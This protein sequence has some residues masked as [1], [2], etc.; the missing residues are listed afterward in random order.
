MPEENA[1]PAPRTTTTHTAGSLAAASVASASAAVR[2]RSSA[3]STAG[4]FSVMVATPRVTSY[5]TGDSGMRRAL[6]GGR[7]WRAR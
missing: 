7:G 5:R 2:G 1:R 6:S 4:R 3:L